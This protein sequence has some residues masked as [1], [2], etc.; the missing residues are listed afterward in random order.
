MG[1]S[2]VLIGGIGRQ[3][4]I[5]ETSSALAKIG[6]H[7][8]NLL[9]VEDSIGGAL[10]RGELVRFGGWWVGVWRIVFDESE[11]SFITIIQGEW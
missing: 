10:L 9:F 8:V 1:A 5:Q 3:Q 6:I 2:M 4:G 7:V 11:V